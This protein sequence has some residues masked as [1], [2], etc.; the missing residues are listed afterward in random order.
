MPPVSTS[1]VSIEKCAPYMWNPQ[2]PA[3]V[4]QTKQGIVSNLCEISSENNS[5]K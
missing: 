1:Q 2:V 5:I 4:H 3:K